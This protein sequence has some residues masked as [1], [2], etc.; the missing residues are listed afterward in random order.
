MKSDLTV[1]R[2]TLL[3]S[4]MTLG[5]ATAA[6]LVR[7]ASQ[8]T[9]TALQGTAT[10][11]ASPGATPGATPQSG[12]TVRVEMTQKAQ[13]EPAHIEISVGTTVEWVNVSDMAHTATCDPEQNPFKK[14][15]PELIEL[16]H[17]AEPWGS[18]MM[19]P[20]DT[21]KHTFTTPGDYKYICNPHVLSG[22]EG[23]ITVK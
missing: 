10:P 14:T 16:P 7:A 23:T 2:R 19:R 11:A 9:A 5:A 17:D 13:F 22:M 4:G 3:R 20:G 15:R 1:N 21:F 6:M 12:E 18:E 8:S